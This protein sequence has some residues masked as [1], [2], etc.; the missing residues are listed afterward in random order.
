MGVSGAAATVQNMAPGVASAL[1][2]TVS[3][4]LVAIPSVFG[5]NFLLTH[6]KMMIT[7][8]ENFASWLADR[9]ELELEASKLAQAAAAAATTVPAPAA[10][11]VA[12]TP[13]MPASLGTPVQA[14]A[15]P[16]APAVRPAPEVTVT[17]P[18]DPAVAAVE[19]YL[20]FDVSDDG[21]R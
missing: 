4:L 7:E 2:A 20:R 19:R 12:A 10:V 14:A 5:Y 18:G 9:M 1:L 3:G 15:V 11:P 21:K 6:V 16:V 8:I 13:A 17:P